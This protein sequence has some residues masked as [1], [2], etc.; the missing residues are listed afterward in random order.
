[1]SPGKLRYC[2]IRN[3]EL[4]FVLGY[5]EKFETVHCFEVPEHSEAPNISH[6]SFEEYRQRW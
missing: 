1:M 5:A 4:L 3:L 6:G 2:N